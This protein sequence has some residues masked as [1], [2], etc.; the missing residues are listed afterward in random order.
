MCKDMIG[1]IIWG[2][3]GTGLEIM[4]HINMLEYYAAIKNCF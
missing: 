3:L 4:A 2:Q 1:S